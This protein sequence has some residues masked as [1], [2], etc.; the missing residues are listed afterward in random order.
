MW[1][2]KGRE[3]CQNLGR[4]DLGCPVHAKGDPIS[5]LRRAL[6]TGRCELRPE[7]VVTDVLLDGTRK[8]ARQPRW[9]ECGGVRREDAA[10]QLDRQVGLDHDAR[11]GG[12]LEAGLALDD[13][14]RPDPLRAEHGRTARDD[15]GYLL[16]GAVGARR[17]GTASAAGAAGSG[18]CSRTTTERTRSQDPSSSG[19]SSSRPT[20]SS[21]P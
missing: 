5:S 1:G 21:R 10:Q 15:A 18:V 16:N 11:L 13:H 4:C 3:G 19:S 12:V 6:Q 7:S 8:T 20:T 9:M 2:C 14:Q 17:G